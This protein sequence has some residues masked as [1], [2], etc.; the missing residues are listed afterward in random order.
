VQSIKLPALVIWGLRDGMLP[1][2]TPKRILK[3]L[4]HA[5]FS[6]MPGSGHTP[7]RDDPE[8][9]AGRVIDFMTASPDPR[10]AI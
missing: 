1:K 4:P 7:M 10:P 6:P 9:F 8:G 5:S 2:S 3:D